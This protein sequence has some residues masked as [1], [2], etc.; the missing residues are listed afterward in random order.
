MFEPHLVESLLQRGGATGY[1]GR[2]T[3]LLLY[4]PRCSICCKGEVNVFSHQQASSTDTRC[5]GSRV[6]LI[7]GAHTGRGS[8]W[9][10]T[11]LSTPVCKRG[12]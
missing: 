12:V 7:S 9:V 4:H 5:L 2:S 10:I 1:S 3:Y 11:S 8:F 6:E